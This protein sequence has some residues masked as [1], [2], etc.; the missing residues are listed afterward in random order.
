[1][2]RL[3]ARLIIAL[4]T[5]FLGAVAVTLWAVGRPHPPDRLGLLSANQQG[6]DKLTKPVV[7]PNESPK[8]YPVLVR[9]KTGFIDNTG[10]LVIP[11]KFEYGIFTG[12]GSGIFSDGMA[13]IKSY[14]G[15]SPKTAYPIYRHGYMDTTGK[16]VIPPQYEEAEA[17]SEGLAAVKV[18]TWREGYQTT[19]D[20]YGYIDK[21]GR[22]ALPARFYVAGSF[23]EGL[24]NV[25]E[26]GVGCGY[27]DRTGRMVL[28]VPFT[29]LGEFREGVAS[30]LT[31]AGRMVFIDRTGRLAF[32]YPYVTNGYDRFS[33]GLLPV[34][35]DRKVGFIDK[36]GRMIIEPQ[37]DS[38]YPFSDGMAR[39]MVGGKDGYVDK[40]GRVVIEP[41]YS[42]AGE[43]SEGLAP[44]EI[45]G[46][47]GYI[48]KA[49]K[50]VIKPRFD[51]AGEFVEGIA[52]VMTGAVHADVPQTGAKNGYIDR[53]GKY[54]WRPS[55]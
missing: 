54:V 31:H 23:S 37:F 40:T 19:Q 55:S 21:T 8:L 28:A 3:T 36:T 22:M 14:H 26:E 30:A 13:R 25:C 9:G 52:P 51:S 16:V 41:Q 46:R 12:A 50:V 20:R 29:G 53:A 5:F 34:S 1:M 4:L 45:N 49:G 44:V 24:A 15:N 27:I 35:V 42:L 17:F 43:F 32:E 47:W 39:V 11:A 6:T 18:S 2:N 38:A 7:R 10:K 33:D 48:D